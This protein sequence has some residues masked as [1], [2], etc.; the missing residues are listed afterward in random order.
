M[1]ESMHRKD[2]THP[3]NR[4]YRS[5]IA[6]LSELVSANLSS[7]R[8]F[9]YTATVQKAMLHLHTLLFPS[10]SLHVLKDVRRRSL[11]TYDSLGALRHCSGA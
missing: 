5:G 3:S 11:T 4:T 1:I 7:R 9:T 2:V 8:F 6:G 10:S